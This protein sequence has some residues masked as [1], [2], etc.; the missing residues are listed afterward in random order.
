MELRFSLQVGNWLIFFPVHLV[1]AQQG[2]DVVAL[3][4]P[5]RFVVG[6]DVSDIAVKRAKEVCAWVVL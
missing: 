3:A 6:L 4:S 2:Y 1:S 5:E